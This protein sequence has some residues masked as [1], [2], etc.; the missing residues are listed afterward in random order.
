MDYYKTL[1]IERSSSQEDIKKA[2]RK[3][4]SQ[5]HPDKGG[6]TARF[7]QIQEAY[8]TLS[9][10]QK[11]QQ[12]DNP[13]IGR[14]SSDN[15]G[16]ATPGFDI[17][18]LFSQMFGEKRQQAGFKQLLRTQINIDLRDSYEGRNHNIFLRTDQTQ[19]QLTIQI[20]K[21]VSTGDRIKL[22]NVLPNS[23]LIIEFNVQ[24]DLKYDRKGN[25]LYSNHP[26]S[27]LDLIAGTS[28]EFETMSG[29][30]VQVH[31]KAGTQP[32]MQ[33]KLTGFGMPVPNTDRYGDQIILLKPF[34]PD[35]IPSEV[36]QSILK[37]RINYV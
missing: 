1:G 31:V 13:N 5:H 22:D 20:P 28:F 16:F 32:Y 9:D 15:F 29:K 7:Q 26:I 33:L 8:A 18:D 2:Y 24:V 21:G 4:A 3:L 14:F 12:Y 19:H 36:I 11:K 23:V 35:N 37:A 25:D 6:D 34:I 30:T 10:P 17:N 27:V